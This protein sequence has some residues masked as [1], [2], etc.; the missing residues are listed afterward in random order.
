MAY[1]IQLRTFVE[2]Y[3]CGNISKA[4]EHLGLS[5]PAATAH[6]QTMESVVGKPLFTRRHRGVDPTDAAH[7]LAHQVAGHMDA[8]EQKVA[9]MRAHSTQIS[10]V[11]TLAGPPEY[12]SYVASA[13]LANLL[14][15]G[16]LDIA[17]LPGNR[18]QIYRALS[19][20]SAD[21]A[22]TASLPEASLYDYA[23]LDS[24]EL[25]LVA[26]PLLAQDLSQ[27]SVTAEALNQLPVIS[28]DGD[29]PLIRE[30]FEFAFG[31]KCTSRQ[32][33]RCP[34]IRAIAGMVHTGVGY[35]VLPDYLC[36][37]AIESGRLVNLGPKGPK[38]ALY[39]AWRK[40]ALAQPRVNFAKEVLVD[41]SELN[42]QG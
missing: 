21:L 13:Q 3:R 25:M 17:I 4:A 2:V 33:A 40:G 42:R 32:I 26:H 1:F 9:S 10:G 34:D 5:Q 27:G 7:D 14:Q 30:Y 18:E 19:D 39:L 15:S 38:N 29:L 22:I 24:E 31:Q 16:H 35:S 11:I 6:I 12:I 36:G 37:E 41:F 8:I 28:Y 20:G 23:L